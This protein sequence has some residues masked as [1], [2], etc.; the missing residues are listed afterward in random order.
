MSE[1]KDG[2]PTGRLNNDGTL[3]E[4]NCYALKPDGSHRPCGTRWIPVTDEMRKQIQGVS[5]VSMIHVTPEVAEQLANWDPSPKG[6]HSVITTLTVGELRPLEQMALKMAES[7]GTA[8]I[9]GT[10]AVDIASPGV[11]LALTNDTSVSLSPLGSEANTTGKVSTKDDQLQYAN[12]VNAS[13]GVL[14]SGGSVSVL[15]PPSESDVDSPASPYVTVTV[16]YPGAAC[17]NDDEDRRQHER[18]DFKEENSGGNVNYYCVP[19]DHPKRPERAPYVFEVE[20]LIQALNM[21]FHEGTV[22][23]SLV[24]SCVERELGMRKVGADYVRDAEKM[25]HSSQET[26]RVRKLRG[27]RG[28]K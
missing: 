21:T 7:I 6:D 3:A 14:A 13:A 25:I 19:I 16:P 20:D 17:T 1:L 27:K 23:K 8:S 4:V 22:L 2:A 12:Q 26:L 10:A 24:R 28:L 15:P 11:P 9:M 5:T 18:R